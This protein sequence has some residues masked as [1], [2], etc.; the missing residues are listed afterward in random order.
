MLIDSHQHFWA[1]ERPEVAWPPA[2]LA[3]IH[4]SFDVGDLRAAAEGLGLTGTVLVQSQPDDRDTDWLCELA[5]REPLVLGLVGWADLL[6]ND[7]PQRIATLSARPKLRG[8]RPMLQAL[9]TEW[10]LQPGLA[11]AL[12]AMADAGLSFDALVVPGQLA[13]VEAFAK[14]WPQIPVVIDHAGKPAIGGAGWREWSAAIERLAALPQVHAKLSGLL[15][16]APP[17]AGDEVIAPYVA[18]LIACFGADRLMWGSDWPVVTLRASYADWL[19]RADRLAG[20][21]GDARQA[22]MGGTARRFYRLSGEPG[23]EPGV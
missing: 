10:I 11:P 3:A 4:R 1:I 18:H 6:A 21:T 12:R 7:A 23:R 17:G 15:T 16:E 20:L 9:P 5:A 19:R 8:L 13:A 14:A 22:V 2:E